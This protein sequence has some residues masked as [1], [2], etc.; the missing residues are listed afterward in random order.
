MGFKDFLAVM[1]DTRRFF[2]SMGEQG[3]TQGSQS[4]GRGPSGLPSGNGT[5]IPCPQDR[6]S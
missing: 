5:T 3:R 1:T 2:C 4:Q 6:T